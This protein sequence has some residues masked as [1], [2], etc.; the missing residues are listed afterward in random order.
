[1]SLDPR[2]RFLCK[3]KGRKRA[4]MKISAKKAAPDVF[5]LTFDDAEI[6]LDGKEVKNL[7]IQLTQ[8]LVPGG[9]VGKDPEEKTQEFVRRA[10]NAND[11]GI[12]R[13]IGAVDHDDV[14]VL[15]KVA[16]G[17]EALIQKFKANMSDKS[18]KMMAEDLAY[19]F[20][21]TVPPGQVTVAISRLAAASKE[22]E[23]EGVLFYEN[24][25]SR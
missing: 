3:L 21:D 22:L 25:K 23:D 18:W 11:V 9:G 8:V 17:N 6:V 12:Q 16:E 2:I 10:K 13:L 19:K 1:M 15:L 4:S 7:L 24:V 14:L 20:K 5:V